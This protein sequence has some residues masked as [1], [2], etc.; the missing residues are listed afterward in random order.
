MRERETDRQT[1]ARSRPPCSGATAVPLQ[2]LTALPD[3]ARAAT[4][5]VKMPA[6]AAI[7]VVWPASASSS[8]RREGG[9]RGGGGRGCVG[10]HLAHVPSSSS[11]R[12]LLIMFREA[13]V[14]GH[15]RDQE[16]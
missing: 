9:A 4:D 12:R 15:A 3:G 14:D 1:D 6:R 5:A 10:Q 16:D 7:I 8:A 11:R 2:D 13:R